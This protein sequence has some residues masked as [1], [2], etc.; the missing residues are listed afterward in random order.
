MF[1]ILLFISTQSKHKHSIRAWQRIVTNVYDIPQNALICNTEVS[2][3]WKCIYRRKTHRNS[4]FLKN[5]TAT[6]LFGGAKFRVF[7][8]A[9]IKGIFYFL[10][11]NIIITLYFINDTNKT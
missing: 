6:A 2:L 5:F 11:K 7:H 1:Y 9:L 10:S 8:A 4:Y 3:L